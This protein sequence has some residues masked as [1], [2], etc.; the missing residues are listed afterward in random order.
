MF[1]YEVQVLYSIRL[2]LEYSGFI[3]EK[4]YVVQIQDAQERP[5]NIWLS[6]SEINSGSPN[7]LVG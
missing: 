2:R 3:K 4:V 1:N 6:K 5:T 7:I